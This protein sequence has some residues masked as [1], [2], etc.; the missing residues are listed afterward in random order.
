MCCF[1][2]YFMGVDSL[3][4]LHHPNLPGPPFSLYSN[5]IEWVQSCSILLC[6]PSLKKMFLSVSRASSWP[7]LTCTSTGYIDL[8][9][10]GS[11]LHMRENICLS[12]PC[13]S[14]RIGVC[15]CAWF[16]F[17]RILVWVWLHVYMTCLWR[18]DEDLE[19]W[20]SSVEGSRPTCLQKG[21]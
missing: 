2:T 15:M 17:L 10:R 6:S 4:S 12:E 3:A 19:G 8:T 18:S 9:V 20:S 21:P 1:H 16:P 5:I 14:Q 7:S 11:N 13:L